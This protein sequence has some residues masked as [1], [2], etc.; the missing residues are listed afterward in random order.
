M[1]SI[2][3]GLS[4]IGAVAAQGVPLTV[5][6]SVPT[7]LPSLA[8][9]AFPS[10][11]TDSL[12]SEAVPLTDLTN[13]FLPGTAL[14]ILP[15]PAPVPGVGAPVDFYQEMP[16][17]SFQH[18]GYQELDCGY[19]YEKHDDGSCQP[20]GWYT[21][22]AH[23]FQCYAKTIINNVQVQGHCP[24]AHTVTVTHAV[25]HVETFTH[26][27]PTT[28]FVTAFQT[29]TQTAVQFLTETQVFTSVWV[30]PTTKVWISTEI[31]DRTKIV[32]HLL[33]A[34]ETATLT[35]VVT[36]FQT[37]TDTATETIKQTE[38]QFF[39]QTE[40]KTIVEPTTFVSIW[41]VTKVIDNTLTQ[42]ETKTATLTE[43]FTHLQT[44][45]VTQT[46]INDV[47]HT[48]FKTIE[49]PT[50]FTSVWVSTETQ[51]NFETIIKSITSV[52][53]ENQ[54][55]TVT[56]VQ[57]ATA[58]QTEVQKVLETGLSECLGKCKSAWTIQ[59]GNSHQQNS[60]GGSGYA[61]PS[62]HEQNAYA[63]S[64]YAASGY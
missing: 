50:T 16:Y 20:I 51:D 25:T 14:P 42:I 26:V 49:V 60:Y 28:V 11:P 39:T 52:V 27:V 57:T 13:A 31:I 22:E 15:T 24:P 37:L 18:G 3:F 61:P 33:T 53:T 59:P 6:P 36:N 1:K 21:P 17:D 19:G 56:E 41:P 44:A 32:E 34:T 43:Q 54:L 5:P 64:G 2:I 40:V 29:E 45:F 35:A 10:Q 30:Q 47:T 62:G 12:F 55:Q 63:G 46:Q 58:T 9:A 48:Q 4:L 38:T 8:D 7:G 23:A